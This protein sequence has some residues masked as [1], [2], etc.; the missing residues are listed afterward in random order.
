MPNPVPDDALE[1]AKL[2]VAQMCT[3]DVQSTVK[4]FDTADVDS[5]IDKTWIVSGQ[6]PDQQKLLQ[7]HPKGKS[8]QIEG[9]YLI[10]LRDRSINYFTLVGDAVPDHLFEDDEDPDG[11]RN[12]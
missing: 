12:A 4:T 11:M 5:S 2:A 10:W 6:S 3:I 7:N 9:P 8:V 1:L